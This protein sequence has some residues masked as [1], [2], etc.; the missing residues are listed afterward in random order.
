MKDSDTREFQ[1]WYD[2]MKER[3]SQILKDSSLTI[4]E[5]QIFI[6]RSTE[7]LGT[8]KLSKQKIYTTNGEK[9]TLSAG[10]KGD[11][12]TSLYRII[13]RYNL[14]M[15]GVELVMKSFVRDWKGCTQELEKFGYRWNREKRRFLK[16][17]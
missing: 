5:K 16:S 12:N 14:A 1:E 10:S 9:M 7:P 8:W 17:S 13:E 6:E 3:A 11:S 4:E 15:D 2:L